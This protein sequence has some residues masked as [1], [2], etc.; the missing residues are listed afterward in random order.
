MNVIT[1]S[2]F[3]YLTFDMCQMYIGIN[4]RGDVRIMVKKE[5]NVVLVTGASSGIGYLSAKALAAKGHTV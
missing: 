2:Y 5:G 4:K 1:I 3:C